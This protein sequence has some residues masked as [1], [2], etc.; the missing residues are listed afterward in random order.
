MNGYFGV[1]KIIGVVGGIGS[2]KTSVTD[3]LDSRYGACIVDADVVA[4]DLVMPGSS[5]LDALVDAFG[6]AILTPE[7]HYDR[8]FVAQVVF[9]STP[10]LRRLNAITHAAIGVEII[11]QVQS[12]TS[13]LV[14]VAL[15]LF[16]VEHRHLFGLQRVWAVLSSP[17]VAVGRLV[18]YRG[19][20]PHDAQARIR[21]QR[22]PKIVASECD[23]VIANDGSLEDL[24]RNV[25]GL[26]ST[27]RV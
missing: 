9:E 12:A 8:A 19:F 4:R 17:E 16:R 3:Y 1:V 7:G 11:R 13:E 22:D 27:L 6:N 21:S 23:E 18:D 15:P 2:G 20:D 14:A 10:A 5:T 25:D 26:M 24:Y